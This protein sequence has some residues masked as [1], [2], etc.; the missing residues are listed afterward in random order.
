MDDTPL[1]KLGFTPE[2]DVQAK[3]AAQ[4]NLEGIK[5]GEGFVSGMHIVARPIAPTSRRGPGH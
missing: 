4:N 3:I 1:T 2:A 5:N